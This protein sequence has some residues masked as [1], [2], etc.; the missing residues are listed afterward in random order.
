MFETA[1]CWQY[2][3]NGGMHRNFHRDGSVDPVS[4][5]T[6]LNLTVQASGPVLLIDCDGIEFYLINLMV[7][8]LYRAFE[9]GIVVG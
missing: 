4:R 3:S 9:R 5:Y 2:V 8:Y 6:E 7:V 1:G